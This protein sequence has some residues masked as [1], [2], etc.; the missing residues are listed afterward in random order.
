MSPNSSSSDR[1]LCGTIEEAKFVARENREQR[2]QKP[3]PWLARKLIVFFTIGIMGY[4]LYIY[5]VRF[6]IQQG[7]QRRQL[8]IGKGGI[9]GLIVGFG[10]LWF[11]MV[12]GY[13]MVIFVSPGFAKHYVQPSPPPFVAPPVAPGQMMPM[14]ERHGIAGP[15]YE[16][17]SNHAHET[18]TVTTVENKPPENAGMLDS[19]RPPNPVALPNGYGYLPPPAPAL[20]TAQAAAPESIPKNKSTPS[21]RKEARRQAAIQKALQ[22]GAYRRPPNLG[23]PV[24]KP[25]YRYC[26]KCMFIK[27]PRTHHC[28]AC[29]TCVLRYDHHCPWIGGCVGARNH[30]YFMN[31]TFATSIFT[32]YTLSTLLG[33]SLRSPDSPLNRGD[34]DPQVLLIVV[35]SALFWLFTTLLCASHVLL[36]LRNQT[37]VEN[38]GFRSQTE[39]EDAQLARVFGF[40]G[41]VPRAAVRKSWDKEYGRVGKEN[42]IW[43]LGSEGEPF[44]WEAFYELMGTPKPSKTNPWGWAA[45]VFPLPLRKG[46]DWGLNFK[47]NDRFD[48]TGAWVGRRI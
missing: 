22:N 25:E 40:W 11:W 29:G 27:P 24:L 20:S 12:W 6:C 47:R 19:I 18:T 21:S 37:T 31:F 43:W 4:A 30:K 8:G 13:A 2:L 33:F 7:L 28:R 23:S 14:E 3:Q 39:R 46:D 10:I 15:S 35:F 36:T 44:D 32:A 26:S 42:N 17:Q 1:T 48:E 16:E 38:L 5:I 41:C 34:I 45:W 9:A